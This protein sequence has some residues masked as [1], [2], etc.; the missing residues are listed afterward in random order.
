[1]VDGF[2]MG[3]TYLTDKETDLLEKL[4]ARLS[5][6]DFATMQAILKKYK[7]LGERTNERNSK[8]I[9][10]NG[11]SERSKGITRCQRTRNDG[12]AIK[13]NA[14]KPRAVH[15]HG[16]PSTLGDVRSGADGEGN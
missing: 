15:L 12:R 7:S 9:C 11:E 16:K 6:E 14:H 13:E 8:K 10:G 4:A 5:G 1:M 3:K 2:R